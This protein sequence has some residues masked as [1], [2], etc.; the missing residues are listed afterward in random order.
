MIRACKRC[1]VVLLIVMSASG[2]WNLKEPDHQAFVMGTGLDFTSDGRFELSTLIAIPAGIGGQELG[3]KKKSNRVLSAT[4]KNNSDAA[5]NLQNQLSRSLF[6]GHREII[7]IGERMARHGLARWADESFRN[8]QSEIRSSVFVVKGGRAK[9]VL[10]T[11]S[12]F[13]PY[14]T[15]ALLGG[16]ESLG[17]RRYI[18][19]DFMA[20]FW[21]QGS[22]PLLP[23]VRLN[24]AKQFENAGL[25]ILDKDNGLTLAGYLNRKEAMFANWI[26][27]RQ[28]DGVITAADSRGGTL[29]V[30]L[31]DLSRN[32]RTKLDGDQIQAEIALAGKGIFIENNSDWEPIRT[33]D[34][35]LVQDAL[36]EQAKQA[37]LD[38][39][40]KAQ[41][42]YRLDLFRIGNSLHKQHPIEW[43]ALRPEWKH[44]FPKIDIAVSIRIECKDPGQTGSTM[45]N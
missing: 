4:G 3:A 16:Q 34:L 39:A 35:A 43:K 13:D 36:N 8:P 1:L 32:I 38:L 40:A 25:A 2:C 41:K 22:L 23:A 30:K 37:V 6:F 24:E 9:D 12:I 19:K 20:D 15:T 10:N 18:F 21:G 27:G 33:K 11:E 26:I 45:M 44:I 14:M 28:T 42:Q 7:L 5:Q 29:S 31:E 17:L